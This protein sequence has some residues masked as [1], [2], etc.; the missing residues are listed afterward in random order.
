M[1]G[2]DCPQGDL[3][4]YGIDDVEFVAEHFDDVVD[5]LGSHGVSDSQM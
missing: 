1:V 2:D 3:Y 4:R 5:G